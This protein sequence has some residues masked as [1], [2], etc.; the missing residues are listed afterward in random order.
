M[1]VSGTGSIVDCPV[2]KGKLQVVLVVVVVVVVQEMLEVSGCIINRTA[3]AT[4]IYKFFFI[5]SPSLNLGSAGKRL[6]RTL[7]VNKSSKLEVGSATFAGLWPLKKQLK[8]IFV[9]RP[10]PLFLPHCLSFALFPLPGPVLAT[11]F[12]LSNCFNCHCHLL[13]AISQQLV[14][15]F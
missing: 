2:R 5:E 1:V 4:S 11:V 7:S 8:S 12:L 15:V 6:Q 10:Q 3:R 9:S 13:L 14:I